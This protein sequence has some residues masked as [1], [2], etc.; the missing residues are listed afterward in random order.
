[1]AH[2]LR[3]CL[4][5]LVIGLLS[6]APVSAHAA[7]RADGAT[8]PDLAPAAAD[9]VKVV[10]AFSE[11]IRTNH[12][13]LARDQLDPQV[14]ILESGGAE[15]GRDE[16]MAG[17]AVEDAAFMGNATVQIRHRRARAEGDFA[18]VAT[19]STL[20]AIDEGKPLSLSSTETMLLKRTAQGWKI[21][22]VHWSSHRNKP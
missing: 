14:L 22:H 20:Q 18:W 19:E 1:M 21:V 8:E 13:D 17:H 16:Y 15:H 2:A 10:D 12:L 9:A 3:P 11:A 7:V 4:P 5:I 6:G